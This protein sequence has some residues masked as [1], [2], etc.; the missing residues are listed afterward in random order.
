MWGLNICRQRPELGVALPKA[1]RVQ[2]RARFHPP[3]RPLDEPDKCRQGE[4]SAWAPTWDDYSYPD[5]MPFHHPEYFGHALL[6]VGKKKTPRP[7]K[8]FELI[9][10]SHFDAGTVGPW[11]VWR[12]DNPN[13]TPVLFDEG[14]RGAGKSLTFA[15][16]GPNCSWGSR[17]VV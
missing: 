17:P 15:G 9:Y 10:K 5:A 8:V 1:A 11:Y 6:E 2:G 3:I 4:W 16:G 12:A 14:F 13:D 7:N